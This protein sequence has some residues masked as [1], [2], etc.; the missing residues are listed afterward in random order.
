MSTTSAKTLFLNWVPFTGTRGEDLNV[1]FGGTQS[2]HSEEVGGFFVLPSTILVALGLF[3]QGTGGIFK[4]ST[5]A[6]I[7]TQPGPRG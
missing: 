7:V 3:H 5:A 1:S 6:T 2:A 4:I